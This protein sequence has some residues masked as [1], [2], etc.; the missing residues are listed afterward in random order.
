MSVHVETKGDHV[1]VNSSGSAPG[2][3]HV[4]SVVIDDAMEKKDKSIPEPESGLKS[5]GDSDFELL[6]NTTKKRSVPRSLS[7]KPD[8][9]PPTPSPTPDPPSSPTRHDHHQEE[10]SPEAVHDAELLTLRKKL[11]LLHEL[12]RKG[13]NAKKL[14]V[15]SSMRDIQLALE[16][17]NNKKQTETGLFFARN[18]LSF[19]CDGMNKLNQKLDPFG[20]SMDDWNQE[21]KYNIRVNGQYD[22]PLLQIVSEMQDFT[23]LPPWF[24]IVAGLSISFYSTA[25]TKQNDKVLR[26]QLRKQQLEMQKQQAELNYHRTEARRRERDAWNRMRGSAP[27][28]P[29]PSA[30]GPSLTDPPDLRGPTLTAEEMRKAMEEANEFVPE[31][32]EEVPQQPEKKIVEIDVAPE[33]PQEEEPVKEPV[34]EVED[35]N[36]KVKITTKKAK[37]TGVSSTKRKPKVSTGRVIN[38]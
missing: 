37:T 35:E 7:A 17:V 25:T 11:H 26:E 10:L 33:E 5:D 36:V 15:D 9:A 1:V 18:A 19:L 38:L 30:S 3:G 6:A 14:T 29:P 32:Q 24:Q 28:P 4:T 2:M 21:A 31:E 22:D 20:V 12:D 16:I 34:K 8:V 27:P 23:Q 13:G